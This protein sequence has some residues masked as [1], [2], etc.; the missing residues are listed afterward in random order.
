MGLKIGIFSYNFIR[1]VF[2]N[3]IHLEV[4]SS[5]FCLLVNSPWPLVFALCLLLL[6]LSAFN[7][8]CWKGIHFSWSNFVVLVFWGSFMVFSLHFLLIILFYFFYFLLLKLCYL[9]PSFG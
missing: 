7:L 4:A 6:V 1:L 9:Y 8:Y 5:P 3:S 2:Y